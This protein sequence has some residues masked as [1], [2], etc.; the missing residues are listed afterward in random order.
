MVGFKYWNET[1][2]GKHI[3]DCVTRAITFASGLPYEKVKEKLFYTGKLLECDPLC[4]NCYDFL[5]SDY[6]NFRRIRN[7]NQP[8]WKF[9]EDH[10][11][12]MFLTRSNGHITL[13]NNYCVYDTWDSR[14]IN[15]TDVWVL[16]G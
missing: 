2:N 16:R 1:P 9:A 7:I 5:L 14:N 13:L 10:K 4:V 6:F 3:G 8:L 12:G 15:L 11:K